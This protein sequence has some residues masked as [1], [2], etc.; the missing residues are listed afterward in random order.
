M[1]LTSLNEILE[2]IQPKGS[3]M[4]GKHPKFIT[5]SVFAPLGFSF[6]VQML[7]S[8]SLKNQPIGTSPKEPFPGAE[9]HCSGG[10][11]VLFVHRGCPRELLTSVPPEL[12]LDVSQRG[13]SLCRRYEMRL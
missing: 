1:T 9:T 3:I 10:L 7:P 13:I 5:Q 4:K 6:A 12:D 8:E 2:T 11:S